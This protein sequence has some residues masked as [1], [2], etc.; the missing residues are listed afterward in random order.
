MR[1]KKQLIIPKFRSEAEDA[2]WHDRHR[3]ELEAEMARRIEN[4]SAIMPPVYPRSKL[5]PV[6]I[7]LAEEDLY[8]A[9]AIAAKKGIGYQTYIKLILREALQREGRAR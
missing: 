1:S 4:G 2:R 5:R 8:K 3:R 6:T 9:R 7:R